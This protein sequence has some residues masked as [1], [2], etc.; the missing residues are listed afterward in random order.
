MA[1]WTDQDENTGGGGVD[2]FLLKEDGFFL[3]LENGGKIILQE[4]VDPTPVWVD[5]QKN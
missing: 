1:T 3:L 4:G 5:Q 2:T